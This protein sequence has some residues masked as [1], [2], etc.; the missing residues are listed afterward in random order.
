MVGG[1]AHSCGAVPGLQ[2][3]PDPGLSG[4]HCNLLEMRISPGRGGYTSPS[5]SF[6]WGNCLNSWQNL[7]Q[8]RF[9]LICAH[10]PKVP[11][12]TGEE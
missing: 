2:L 1:S 3:N 9:A 11:E 8:F 4:R 12:I 10:S 7:E 5:T 6:G